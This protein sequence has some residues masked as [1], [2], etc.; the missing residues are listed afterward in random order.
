LFICKSIK[1]EITQDAL[2]FVD[3][4]FLK[5]EICLDIRNGGINIWKYSIQ[6]ESDDKKNIYYLRYEWDEKISKPK[7]PP[8]HLHIMIIKTRGFQQE[9]WNLVRYF[10]AL[11]F[12]LKNGAN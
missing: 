6:W 4:S 5:F 8:G 2:W 1:R 10:V 3:R 7:H 12:G 9:S 11:K